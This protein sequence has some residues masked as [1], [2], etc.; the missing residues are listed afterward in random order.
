MPLQF[1]FQGRRGKDRLEGRKG[2]ERKGKGARERRKEGTGKG[3]NERNGKG[4]GKRAY[5]QCFLNRAV[6]QLDLQ[7][8]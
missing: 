7:Q 4:E 3:R 2:K 5:G 1:F 8:F 6:D